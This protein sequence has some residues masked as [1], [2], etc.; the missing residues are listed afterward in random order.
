MRICVVGTKLFHV[1][2]MTDVT[3]LSR[4]SLFCEC[5]YH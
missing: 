1:D 5:T 3:K 4:F 2:K